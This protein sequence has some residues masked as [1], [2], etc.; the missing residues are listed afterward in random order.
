MSFLDWN[1]RGFNMPRK[2]RKVRRWVHEEKFL[3]GCLLET[4]VQQD[5]Y[6]VCLADALPGWASMANY[7]YNQLGCIWFC[8]SDKVV[9]TRLHISSQ[10]IS[11]AIQIPE[12]WEQFICSDCLCF[13]L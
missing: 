13:K 10:V 12:T 9:A 3:F 2:H 7:E 4:R 6:G 11:Y 1:K 8:W 5:N